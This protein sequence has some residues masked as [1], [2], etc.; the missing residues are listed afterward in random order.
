MTK[1]AKII[2]ALVAAIALVVV[3][4]L[5]AVAY[6]VVTAQLAVTAQAST[7][8][9][10]PYAV[11]SAP[12]GSPTSFTGWSGTKY[13]AAPLAN[14]GAT[15]WAGQTVGISAASGFGAAAVATVQVAFSTA[16]SACQNDATYSAVTPQSALGSSSW[17]STAVV[18]PAA[19]LYACVKLAVT[20][21]DTQTASGQAAPVPSLTLTTSAT[22][23]QRNWTDVEQAALT[24]TSTGWAAC[25]TNT[26]DRTATLTLPAPVA[27]GTYTIVRND[28]GATYTGTV[29]GSARTTLTVT[30]TASGTE[31]ATDT[32]VTVKNSGGTTVAVANLTFRSY[33]V[34][35][36]F[37]IR[38]A[39]CA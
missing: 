38:S 2:T 3:A 9:I 36:I 16:A 6:W 1:R 22:A 11:A 13:Y 31:A 4:P 24:V 23:T 7:F 17:T 8:S 33:Y 25:T 29:S 39:A 27:P 10:A 34:L 28:T 35:F 37:L 21:T 26:G 18:A 32:Y 15:P 30:N 5:S 14:N 19:T 12:A 20:D